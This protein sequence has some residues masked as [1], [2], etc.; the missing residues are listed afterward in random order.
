MT[1][2]MTSLGT[3]KTNKAVKAKIAELTAKYPLRTYEVRMER[4]RFYI[5]CTNA[6]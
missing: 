2:R 6:G 1:N 5:V 3:F 4:N